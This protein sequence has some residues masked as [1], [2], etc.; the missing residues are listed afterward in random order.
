MPGETQ[1]SLALQFK[2]ISL[3]FFKNL[4][5]MYKKNSNSVSDKYCVHVHFLSRLLLNE[6]DEEKTKVCDLTNQK[7]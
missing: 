6:D 7:N 2:K 3:I 4:D 5:L 1:W